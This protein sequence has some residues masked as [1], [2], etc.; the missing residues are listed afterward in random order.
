M[1]YIFAATRHVRIG[2]PLRRRARGPGRKRDLLPYTWECRK[3]PHLRATGLFLVLSVAD[4]FQDPADSGC[5]TP[6]VGWPRGG[7]TSAVWLPL[8]VD[9]DSEFWSGYHVTLRMGVFGA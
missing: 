5:T 1:P 7:D 8:P 4:E 2:T 6:V 9:L 3:L